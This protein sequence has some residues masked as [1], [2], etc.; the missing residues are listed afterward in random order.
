M[1]GDLRDD[2]EG[3]DL[4]NIILMMG[5]AYG[6]KA[7]QRNQLRIERLKMFGSFSGF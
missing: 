4:N 6:F 2:E 1:F 7:T 5:K 3:K